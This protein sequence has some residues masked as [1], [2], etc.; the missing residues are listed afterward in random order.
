MDS[1]K[2]P[3]RANANSSKPSFCPSSGL[4]RTPS[5]PKGT[6]SEQGE[7]RVGNNTRNRQYEQWLPYKFA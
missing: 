1:D 4:L 2:K 3:D 5:P 6:P 7:R